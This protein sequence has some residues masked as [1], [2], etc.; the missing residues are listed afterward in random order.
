MLKIIGIVVGL[1]VLAVIGVLVVAATRPDRF[2]VERSLAIAAPPE[3]IYPQ[4]VSLRRWA[5]WSPYEKK[6]P[7]MQRTFSGPEAGKGAA[8]AWDGDKNVGAGRMEITETSPP[9]QGTPGKV[10]I[11]LQFLRPFEARNIATFTLA[12]AGGTTTVTWAMDGPAPMISKVIG[13]FLD[14]DK[15]IG[16]DFENGLKALKAQAEG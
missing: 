7:A 4:I 9:G 11:D 10:V 3:K 15:M 5:L 13:L 6:D 12:P 2:H 16:G 8:Y 14:M 1:L